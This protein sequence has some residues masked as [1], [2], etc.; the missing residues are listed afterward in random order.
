MR[1][2]GQYACRTFLLYPPPLP[3]GSSMP[4]VLPDQLYSLLARTL[5]IQTANY[6]WRLFSL[7]VM[8]V[9]PTG[10]QSADH[11]QHITVD[12]PQLETRI[13]QGWQYLVCKCTQTGYNCTHSLR[14][15][16]HG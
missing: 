11:G 5:A 6:R 2:V 14:D 12:C 1:H 10:T 9:C 3:A 8:A 13:R 15:T 7:L 16:R 4:V